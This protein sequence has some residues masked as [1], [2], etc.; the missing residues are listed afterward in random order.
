ME[1]DFVP[2]LCDTVNDP[3]LFLVEITHAKEGRSDIS[4]S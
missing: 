4:F 1:S 3:A 2:V